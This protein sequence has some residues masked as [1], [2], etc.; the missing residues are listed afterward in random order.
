MQF[1]TEFSSK[2]DVSTKRKHDSSDS[3]ID[4]EHDEYETF[5]QNEIKTPKIMRPNSA[6]TKWKSNSTYENLVKENSKRLVS[7]IAHDYPRVLDSVYSRV[8]PLQGGNLPSAWMDHTEQ[9]YLRYGIGPTS[10]PMT[11]VFAGI[12]KNRF[13]IKLFFVFIY[14]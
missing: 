12:S 14:V 10:I 3:N 1:P 8:P 9:S 6:F 4:N 5:V 11:P 2:S 7:D 13:M